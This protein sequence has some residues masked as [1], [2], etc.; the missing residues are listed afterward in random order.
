LGSELEGYATIFSGSSYN[1]S[2]G[3]SGEVVNV[4]NYS[5]LASAV[6]DDEPRI[7]Y[8]SGTISRGGGEM[9]DV[10]SNKS[11]LGRGDDAT[12]S[13]FGFNI[14]GD[15]G[16]DGSM[17]GVNR[18]NIIIQNLN[19]RSSADDSINVQC[20]AHNIWIDH[21]TF[22]PSGDGSVDIKRGA[23][24]ITV[25]WNRFNSTRKTLLLGHSDGNRS[26]DIGRLRV[27]YHHNYFKDTNS[28]NPRVRFAEAHVYNNLADNVRNYFIGLGRECNVYADGNYVL[29]AN[30]VT[31]D[32][33]GSRLTWHSSNII[34]E[35]GSGPKSTGDA[36]NPRNYYDYKLD[37]AASVPDLVINGAGS[38]ILSA[39]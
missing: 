8:I 6:A 36:F 20:F 39:P 11:I 35:A 28:R 30:K 4:S 32:Y 23:D 15:C 12:L 34:V 21:N 10:G 24:F 27:S 26:Q 29:S 5:E 25:S 14:T 13:G 22:Y 3:A 7:I 9:L 33:G 38:G 31:A 19:F 18:Q 37:D 16:G 17:S 2:G 1:L